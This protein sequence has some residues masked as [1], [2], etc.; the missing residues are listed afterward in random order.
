MN[1]K[2]IFFVVMVI[3]SVV[4]SNLGLGYIVT[5][6]LG[7]SLNLLLPISIRLSGLFIIAVGVSFLGWTLFY[8]KPSDVMKSTYVTIVKAIKRI[9]VKENLGRAEPL[10]ILGPY[11]YIRHPQYFGAFLLLIGWWLLLDYTFLF[12]GALFLFLWF[13]FILIPF[14]EKELLALFGDQYKNYMIQVPSII[15]FTNVFRN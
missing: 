4:F 8:R 13:R 7:L 2:G 14:E 9:D 5:L 15:P 1:K 10:T 3:F 6:A 11:K 12:F